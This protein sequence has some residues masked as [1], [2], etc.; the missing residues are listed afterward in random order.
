[1]SISTPDLRAIALA[2][3]AAVSGGIFTHLL[4]VL[5]GGGHVGGGAILAARAGVGK[6]FAAKLATVKAVVGENA[7]KVASG[8]I[9]AMA[10]AA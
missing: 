6:G 5:R 2:I 4:W 1:M 9:V 10:V 8:T 7:A 3:P